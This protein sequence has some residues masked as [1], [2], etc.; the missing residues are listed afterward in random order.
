MI[1]GGGGQDRIFGEDGDDRIL[2]QDGA[3]DVIGCGAGRD[4]VFA[5]RIDLVAVDCE[6]VSRR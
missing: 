5:D 6:T 2:A 1:S 4:T 3:F